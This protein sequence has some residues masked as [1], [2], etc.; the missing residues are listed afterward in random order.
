VARNIWYKSDKQ[1]K[2]VEICIFVN[3]NALKHFTINKMMH[4]KAGQCSL[5]TCFA[6]KKCH[7]VTVAIYLLC[8]K[9][10]W[11]VRNIND[12]RCNKFTV[13]NSKREG[14]STLLVDIYPLWTVGTWARL[15]G[16]VTR[17]VAPAEHWILG[18][19]ILDCIWMCGLVS[20]W[21]RGFRQVLRKATCF[22]SSCHR[23]RCWR[24]FSW[25]FWS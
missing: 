11:S 10:S 5:K 25:H 13:A 15:S 17:H 4:Q 22:C 19:F 1:L 8:L 20:T 2:S 16:W 3:A 23:V 14:W 9:F 7:S 12:K 6:T 21:P 24:T 18:R